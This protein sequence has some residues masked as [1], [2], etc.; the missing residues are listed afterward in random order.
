MAKENRC[1]RNKEMNICPSFGMQYNR[2]QGEQRDKDHREGGAFVKVWE[3]E[4][5][6][7]RVESWSAEHVQVV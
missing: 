5:I 6:S 3:W 4:V 1:A 7:P 2:G